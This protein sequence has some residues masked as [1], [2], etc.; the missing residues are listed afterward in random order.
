MNLEPTTFMFPPVAQQLDVSHEK[1]N[2]T[3]EPTK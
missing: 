2:K 1:N 3:S